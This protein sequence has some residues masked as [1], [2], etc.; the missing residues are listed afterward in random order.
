M[1]E[2][3]NN[4]N[5]NF[6]VTITDENDFKNKLYDT[7]IRELQPLEHNGK[8]KGN[9]HHLTQRLTEQIVNDIL[10]GDLK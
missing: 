2:N 10:K 1:S 6:G 8:Y 3:E 7:L 4:I 5:N 9:S